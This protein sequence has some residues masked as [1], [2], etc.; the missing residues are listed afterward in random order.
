MSAHTPRPRV[1]TIAFWCWLVGAAL[2]IVGGTFAVTT[3]LPLL[4]RGAGILTVLAGAGMAFLA[5]H[6]RS[7]DT[8]FRRAAVALSLALVVLVALVFVF[9]VVHILTLLAMIPLIV[10][11]V[12][13]TRP[14]ASAWSDAR[15]EP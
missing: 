10:G 3:D 14:A 15:G 11:T 5:G 6:S 13:M 4:Y 2:L 1:V 9:G 8:R 7:G 12:L